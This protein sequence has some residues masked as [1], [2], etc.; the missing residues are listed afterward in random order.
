M[1]L[2]LLRN[3]YLRDLQNL[4]P[5]EEIN[6]F[7]QL[8]TTHRLGLTRLDLALKTEFNLSENDLDF[9]QNAL[10]ELQKEKPIQYII[11]STEFY[12]LPI[13]VTKDVL[14]P[15]PETEE[16]VDWILNDINQSRKKSKDWSPIQ[17]LDIGTGSGCIAIALAKHLP[18][19]KVVALDVSHKALAIARKNALLN[20]VSVEFKKQDILENQAMLNPKASKSKMQYF[21]LIVSNPP[22]VRETEQH[23]IKKN[24]LEYE[25]HLALFVKDEN[26]LIFYDKIA[27][28]AKNRLIGNGRLYFEINQYLGKEITT[29]L[30]EKNFSDITLRT[31]LFGN[32]RMVRASR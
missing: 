22:Y 28:I 32:N 11:G 17:I 9:F 8:L 6:S 23:N 18:E 12:G 1:T 20:K 16:L 13:L 19:A 5:K 15:R 26:S 30:E 3:R 31:D 4:Y 24:V 29:L 25:P 2:K 14:I 10:A 21:D 27:D 7:F